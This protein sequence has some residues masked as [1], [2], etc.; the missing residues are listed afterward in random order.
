M[1]NK[2]EGQKR[3]EEFHFSV[4]LYLFK[5]QHLQFQ[6]VEP[7]FGDKPD[8][9]IPTSAGK[10]GVEHTLLFITERNENSLQTQEDLKQ[11]IVDRARQISEDNSVPPLR[12][13]I[14]FRVNF[15]N[16]SMKEQIIPALASIIQANCPQN[17]EEIEINADGPENI[18]LPEGIYKL[19]ISRNYWPPKHHWQVI[20]AGW[21]LHDERNDLQQIIIDRLQERINEKDDKYK[22]YII[23][24]SQCWLLIVV[25]RS[26]P[27]QGIQVENENTLQHKFVSNYDRIFYL[28]V[29]KRN[30]IELKRIP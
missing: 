21:V 20:E 10:I 11:E 13:D 22:E 30:L 15:S 26:R 8:L 29:M 18:I 9:L 24:C 27:S 16:G 2:Q 3:L 12:V 17:D 5:K 23:K 14:L 4:F 1:S 25:D 19:F 28:D 7:E 6:D